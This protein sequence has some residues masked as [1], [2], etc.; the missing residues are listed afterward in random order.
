MHVADVRYEALAFESQVA[1]DAGGGGGR[2]R[3]SL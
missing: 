1:T 3:D 2:D